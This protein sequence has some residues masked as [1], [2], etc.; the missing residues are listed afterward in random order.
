MITQIHL[1]QGLDMIT[2][3]HLQSS[4]RSCFII[5]HI[6]LY[7]GLDALKSH[8]YI[9]PILKSEICA[10]NLKPQYCKSRESRSQAGWANYPKEYG[11]PAEPNAA[12][13]VTKLQMSFCSKCKCNPKAA[14]FAPKLL[15]PFCSLT[16]DQ[17]RVM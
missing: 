9:L 3:I 13:F 7:Q 2:Q 14:K 11:L 5:T 16:S 8:K 6:H 17:T 10:K 12:K 4:P 15:M 1:H